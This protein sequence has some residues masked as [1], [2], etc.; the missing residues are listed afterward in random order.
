MENVM[1]F[2]DPHDALSLSLNVS[3]PKDW[4]L[5]ISVFYKLVFVYFISTKMFF[6][7]FKEVSVHLTRGWIWLLEVIKG[8]KFNPN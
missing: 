6:F 7:F 4:A 5:F 2:S 3:L 1:K 8:K